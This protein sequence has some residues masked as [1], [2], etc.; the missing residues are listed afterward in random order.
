MVF[1]SNLDDGFSLRLKNMWWMTGRVLLED[2][3]FW[4]EKLRFL[5][6]GF[7]LLIDALIFIIFL[8]RRV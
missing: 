7:M 2:C 3:A 6:V 5:R 8:L 1:N 4:A